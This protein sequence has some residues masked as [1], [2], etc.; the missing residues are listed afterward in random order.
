ML[1]SIR[2]ATLDDLPA[3]NDIY[4]YYVLNSTCTY[5]L[6]PETL[7]DRE[8]WFEA[9]S[10]DTHPVILAI[11]NEVIVG[12][13]AISQFRPVRRIRACGGSVGLS[14]SRHPRPR[15]RQGVAP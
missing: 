10:P 8:R 13:G 2:L 12:W 4:N 14:S 1:A 11:L 15:Y 3:I 9:H 5:Q 7:E 6:E